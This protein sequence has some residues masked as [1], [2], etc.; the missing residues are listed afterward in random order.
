[1]RQHLEYFLRKIERGQRPGGSRTSGGGFTLVELLVVLALLIMIGAIG[2]P[3][4]KEIMLR[5][6]METF[7]TG[8]SQVFHTARS[9]AVR[10]NEDVAVVI[11]F[12]PLDDN[13]PAVAQFVSV[14]VYPLADL[15]D[16][17]P[18]FA[19]TL[20]SDDAAVAIA[21]VPIPNFRGGE[22]ANV[23]LWGSQDD[24]PW[25]ADAV[26]GFTATAWNSAPCWVPSAVDYNAAVYTSEGSLRD[27]G[28]FRFGMGP[29]RAGGA[30][31]TDV[32]RNFLEVR[33][34]PAAT[35]KVRIRKWV[36]KVDPEDLDADYYVK[37][38]VGGRANWEWYF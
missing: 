20:C 12:A 33:V 34:S 31:N 13:N 9:E 18:A 4:L 24:Q 38:Q 1:M 27:E 35:G 14:E 21:R 22:D 26:S 17:M 16:D 2:A 37:Q 28:S 8:V 3:V 10:G 6:K 7:V 29:F 32:G 5:A 36:P 15:E 23:H 30:A 19:N 11:N 25:G